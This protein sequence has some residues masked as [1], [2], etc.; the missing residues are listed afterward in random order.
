MKEW[1]LNC[2]HC[3][4]DFLVGHNSPQFHF[5]SLIHTHQTFE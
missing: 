1:F 5:H 2:F 3:L 4:E